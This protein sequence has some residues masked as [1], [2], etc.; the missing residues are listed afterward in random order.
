MLA[1]RTAAPSPMPLKRTLANHDGDGEERRKP[2]VAPLREPSERKR[3][4]RRNQEEERRRD[5]GFDPVRVGLP[6]RVLAAVIQAAAVESEEAFEEPGHSQDRQPEDAE[7]RKPAGSERTPEAQREGEDQE[8]VEVRCDL[9]VQPGLVGRLGADIADVVVGRAEASGWARSPSTRPTTKVTGASS[10]Q[11][12]AARSGTRRVSQTR[13]PRPE[14][15]A[16]DPLPE[17][18]HAGSIPAAPPPLAVPARVRSRMK[19]LWPAGLRLSTGAPDSMP[20]ASLRGPPAPAGRSALLGSPRC[21][22]ASAP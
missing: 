16:A 1:A 21:G 4:H 13:G 22:S 11:I 20:A 9:V 6:G 8:P 10:P 2:Q 17:E 12:A 15:C 19:E 3:E 7:P 5:T 14:S 18:R